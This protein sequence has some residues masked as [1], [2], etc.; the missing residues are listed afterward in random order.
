MFI[1][2]S[3]SQSKEGQA[4]LT[5]AEGVTKFIKKGLNFLTIQEISVVCFFDLDK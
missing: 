4:C 3:A 5:I 2:T 1:T